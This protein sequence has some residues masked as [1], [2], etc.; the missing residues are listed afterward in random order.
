MSIGLDV[1]PKTRPGGRS[2][3]VTLNVRQATIDI[4]MES[5]ASELTLEAV[6]ARAEVNRATLYRRWRDKTRLIAWALLET[7]GEE[8]P[9]V[10]KGSL[11]AD[12]LVVMQGVNKFLGTPL[13]SS[14]MQ[15]MA[16]T[17]EQGSSIKSARNEFWANR[18]S[19]IDEVFDRAVSRGELYV[20]EDR[21]YLIDQLF[22]PIYLQHIMG[23]GAVSQKYLKRLIADVLSRTGSSG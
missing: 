16:Q 10:D 3:R 18:L 7:V 11:A 9:Y 20:G 15:I 14:I 13:A 19:R 12:V 22:G 6:A 1:T 4:L 8:V 21:D 23:R 5:S 17:G 2:A